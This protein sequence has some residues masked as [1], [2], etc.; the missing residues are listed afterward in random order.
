[1][2]GSQSCLPSWNNELES[3]SDPSDAEETGPSLYNPVLI[4]L[5][6]SCSFD[7]SGEG[8]IL[9]VQS[10]NRGKSLI[11]THWWGIEMQGHCAWGWHIVWTPYTVEK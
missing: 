7:L 3:G 2:G 10:Q 1:M 6:E 11:D 8:I 5:I 9:D 4:G